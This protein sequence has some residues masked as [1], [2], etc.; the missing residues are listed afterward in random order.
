MPLASVEKDSS[1][2]QIQ[3][4]PFEIGET[5]SCNPVQRFRDKPRWTQGHLLQSKRASDL[6][7]P[8]LSVLTEKLALFQMSNT[9][10]EPEELQ[11]SDSTPTP[12]PPVSP[13]AFPRVSSPE[14][15]G[16]GGRGKDRLL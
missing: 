16:G 15:G 12:P 3:S 2:V 14:P 6:A 4:L 11:R 8:V 5:E 9:R 1:Y 7:V 13:F 10:P